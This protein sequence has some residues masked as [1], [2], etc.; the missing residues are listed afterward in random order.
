MSLGNIFKGLCQTGAWGCFDEF[1]RIPIEVLSVVATQVGS[2]LNA[3]RA[4]KTEFD[5]MGSTI[6]LVNTVGVFITMNPGY[7]G[8]T[9]LPENLKALFRSCAMVVP[10]MEL[11]CENMLMSEG[12]LDA[13]PLAH[14]FITLYSLSKE[15]LSQQMHYDWGLRATKAVLR[16]AGGLKRAEPD[17][18][19]GKVLMRALRDFNLPKIVSQ[20]QPIFLRLISDLFRGME[21]E[22]KLSKKLNDAIIKVTKEAGLQPED[23]FVRKVTELSELFEVRHSV[24]VIGGGGAGK[25]EV[26]KMLLRAQNELGDKS[27]YEAFNPK[28]IRNDELYGWLSASTGDWYDGVLS[29]LM[30][31]MSRCDNGYTASQTY[32]WIVLDSDI[33]P[34]WIES[35]NT[36]MDDNKVLTLVSNERIP[37]SASMRLL[38][39]VAHLKNATPATVSRAGILFINDNDVGWKPMIDS[40]IDAQS[41]EQ[42]RSSLRSLFN[43]YITSD[44]LEHLKK[45]F[46]YVVPISDIQKLRTL[47]YLLQGLLSEKEDTLSAEKEALEKHFVYCLIWAFGGSLLVDETTNYKIEF[48][49]WFKH[50]Y[51]IITYPFDQ[52]VDY[53]SNTVFD[54]FYDDA[55]NDIVRWE[56]KINSYSPPLTANTDSILLLS[57]IVVETSESV[58]LLHYV[59]QMQQHGNPALF[60]GTSGTGKTAVIKSFLKSLSNEK[61]STATINL[62]SYTDATTL[63]DIMGQHVDKRS[64]RNFGPPGG[65]KLIYFID[66]LNM[67]FVDTYG[68]QSPIA[69][70]RQQMDYK[71]WYDT[72]E[73]DPNRKKKIIHDCQYIA[74]M[75]SKAGSFT[76]N[77]RLMGHFATFS[78]S[79]PTRDQLVMIYR[80][81]LDGHLSNFDD[82]KI[83][84]QSLNVTNATIDLLETMSKSPKFKPSS[85]K[86]HY[87]FTMRD[88]SNVFQ[89]LVTSRPGTLS[90]VEFIRM[91][92][93][94]CTRVFGDRLIDQNDVDAFTEVIKELSKKNF[95]DFDQ[96]KLTA[97]PLLF[98]SFISKERAYTPITN[99]EDLNKALESF[100]ADYNENNAELPL[101]LFEM[102]MNHVVR[103]ARIIANPKGNAFLIG[104]GGSGK[105]SL[106]R[107]ASWIC[108]YEVFQIQVTRLYSAADLMEDIKQLYMKCGVKGQGVSFMLTDSQI[109]D[110]KWLVYINDLLSSGD[111]PS[112]FAEDEK[113]SIYSSLRSEFKLH[114]IEDSD[115]AAMHDYFINKV[116]K[117]L[118]LVLCFSP[119]GEAFRVRCRKFPALIN[120]TSLDWF[121]SW[122]YDALTAV[123][124]RFLGES[125]ELADIMDDEQRD[126][127]AHHMAHVHVSVDS[128]STKYY[129]YEKRYNHTT[130]K[131]FLE[132]ID[133]YKKLFKEK[134]DNLYEQIQRLD[135]GIATLQKT[136]KDVSSLKEDL[137]KKL[138]IVEEKK[139]AANILIEKCGKERVKVDAEKA[140]ALEEKGKASVVLN[141]ANGIK[142]E[143]EE[144]LKK[145][146]PALQSAADAVN[147]LTKSSLTELKSLKSPD[148]KILDVTKAVLILK[149]GEKKNHSWKK[150]Q[151]MMKNVDA[152]KRELENYKAEDIDAGLLKLVRPVL[153][154][155]YFNKEMM[156]K[157]SMAAANLCVWVVAIVQY[158]EIYKE[159]APK[160][161]A[162]E[163]AEG[164]HAEA[165]ATLKKVEEQVAAKE[166]QLKMVTDELQAAI[167]DKNAVERDAQNCQD[168]L[169]LAERLVGG[170][171]SENTRWS[172]GVED[173][174]KKQ[175]TLIGDVLLSAA[176][177]SYIGAFN[178]S[179]RKELWEKC[180]LA[181]LIEKEIPVSDAIKSMEMVPKDVLTTVLPS[182][183]PSK[184]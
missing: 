101:V 105:Q 76:V 88:V 182:F 157:I 118:H 95:A 86:F 22:R 54:Y 16:V 39:E 116:G 50:T 40:W 75:N 127:I 144:V 123:A 107:L 34:E 91:W 172:K 165:M 117:N 44:L 132:L 150:A 87:S 111:I 42:L 93:H 60:V 51:Q 125:E 74:A 2:F 152:F 177:V 31:N 160:M 36:V 7:A 145:A 30:R 164:E 128:M 10:D 27:V 140:V 49:N 57:N 148:A 90:P 12:F 73:S 121:F 134:S 104:V 79:T 65:K 46:K 24:F 171:S 52:D 3:L 81:I 80:S 120:C 29:T 78:C 153:E 109:V 99:Y 1:N 183:H 174:Q 21:I 45:N 141:R 15:L 166:A 126:K 173:L 33:D 147:C 56:T 161:A 168:R 55:T 61:Y 159:V 67:P 154:K 108:G 70:V 32:K 124:Y 102:A 59:N 106:T 13:R 180:W 53:G 89:G 38:F 35:L 19:E 113:D 5:L 176:F 62:N 130:P 69:L 184:C 149:D 41:D 133:F 97:L 84:K 96:D 137:I 98:G 71:L 85:T 115:R 143:C 8:R 158:N 103:I 58:R 25:S 135:K 178:M 129:Q 162:A 169:A 64:G 179:F 14:K 82:D 68:T 48:S 155:E 92:H 181:D 119:V 72:T 77:E 28:A 151:S 94:E 131:S 122:P 146:M 114:G 170:L 100:L 23:M 9:E 26:W 47:T 37:L 175:H 112:L 139:I 11:I 4:N 20:D 167:E 43:K 6:K 18:A 17:V 66:D 63:R 110:E 156:G 138:E 136:A 83:I 142:A 163:V